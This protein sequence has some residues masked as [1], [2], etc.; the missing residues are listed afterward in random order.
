DNIALK[1]F[2]HFLSEHIRFDSD[3]DEGHGAL[4]RHLRPDDRIL[5]L[6]TAF[7]RLLVD[8]VP[9]LESMADLCLDQH[10]AKQLSGSPVQVFEQQA[11]GNSRMG[12]TA[13][14]DLS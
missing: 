5:P 1:A 10:M 14:P 9:T 6:W 2:R 13:A 4:S 3:P 11:A 8:F 12:V 7:A